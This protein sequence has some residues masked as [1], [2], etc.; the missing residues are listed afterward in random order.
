MSIVRRR[1][2]LGLFFGLLAC[3]ITGQVTGLIS[4]KDIIRPILY[5]GFFLALLAAH[6]YK[7]S[8]R[9]TLTEDAI[10]VA[11][12]LS[13]RTLRRADIRARR[14]QHGNR[15]SWRHVLTPIDPRERPLK[16]P[17]DIEADAALTEWLRPIPRFEPAGTPRL[18]P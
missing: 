6:G 18:R 3:A 13:I 1:V 7:A 8:R 11:D 15:G 12:W 14:L 16:F 5:D 4:S 9:V 2:G 17:W 10:E